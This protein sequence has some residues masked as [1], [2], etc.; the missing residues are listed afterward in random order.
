MTEHTINLARRGGAEQ[1]EVFAAETEETP[2][3]F[4]ANRLKQVN[5]RQTSGLA[6]RVVKDGRIGFAATTRADGVDELVAA[7][8][9][10]APFGPEA[11]FDFPPSDTYPSV[12]VFDP[13]VDEVSVD[14][15]AHLGQSLIDALR[16]EE[17]ELVCEGRVRKAVQT[18]TC[19]NSSGGR[20][21]YRRSVFTVSVGG[22]LVR[23]TD[24][25]FVG[26]GDSSCRPLLDT[27]AIEESV[28]RQLRYARTTAAAPSGEVPVIFTPLGVAGALVAPLVMAFSGRTVYQGQSPLVGCLGKEMYDRRCSLW[29][30]ATVPFRPPSRICDDEGVSSRRLALVEDGVVRSFLYDLQTAGLAGATSTG[31][32]GR[33]GSGPPAVSPSCLVVAEGDTPLADMLKDVKEG[34]LVEELMG[35]GQGN[36][37]GGDFSGN[38]LLGYKI[39]R[40]EV[41]GRVKDAV[42][43]G[44]VHRALRDLVAIGSEARWVGG[45]LYTP[46][47]YFPRLSVASKS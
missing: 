14:R 6:L 44:N 16:R 24:M 18:V 23:G 34:L 5:R 10:A 3:L 27:K 30:D 4:E 8:L 15:M 29:D 43:A 47:L 45:A 28:A 37:L 26:D 35:A 36:V 39:E 12:D 17:A 22:T 2:V 46:P 19:L 20:F 38:V 32:A 11:K 41:V 9:E 33:S 21:S 7:A 25:L 42:V 1:A 31:S 13:A 40:G